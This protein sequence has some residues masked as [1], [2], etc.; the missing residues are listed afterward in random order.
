MLVSCICPTYGRPPHHLHLLE[1]CV[2]W[3]TRQDYAKRELVI[4][5]DCS[6]QRLICDVD[7]VRVVNLPKRFATLGDKYNALL[8]LCRGEVILPWEDDDISLPHRISQ[9]VRHLGLS[10]YYNPR[11]QW[12]EDAGK[13]HTDHNQGVCHNASAYRRGTV[14]YESVTGSQDAQADFYARTHLNCSPVTLTRPADWDYVYRWGVSDC[15][16]SGFGN[17]DDAYAKQAAIGGTY[18]IVPRMYKD[19]QAE[20]KRLLCGKSDC[21][22]ACSCYRSR[23]A[24]G[25]GA[26]C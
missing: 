2:Y 8:A 17:M 26:R 3:F 25:S 20:T 5:N 19:Y 15:H 12:Y 9:C 16:L 11:G 22:G 1:E 10:D 13:L 14:V 7:R 4:L 23:A 18:I 6:S 21:S 24:G